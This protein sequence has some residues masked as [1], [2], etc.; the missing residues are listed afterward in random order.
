MWVGDTKNLRYGKKLKDS[1]LSVLLWEHLRMGA[2]MKVYTAF[3]L[4]KDGSM[5]GSS[6][7]FSFEMEEN[8]HDFS[9]PL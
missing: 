1:S 8:S 7:T 4:D 6:A 3:Y 2:F 9:M 5:P